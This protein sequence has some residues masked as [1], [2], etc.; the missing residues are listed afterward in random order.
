MKRKMMAVAAAGVLAVSLA[1]CGEEVKTIGGGDNGS[2]AP[3]AATADLREQKQRRQQ[4][5]I[6]LQGQRRA[7]RQGMRLRSPASDCFRIWM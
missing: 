2:N 6:R 3:V 4:M 5:R 7:R 1:A